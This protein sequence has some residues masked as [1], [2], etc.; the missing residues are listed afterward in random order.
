MEHLREAVAREME[1]LRR[2]HLHLLEEAA[3]WL[4]AP[5][6]WELEEE[7]LHWHVVLRDVFEPDIDVEFVPEAIVVRGV[8]GMRAGVVRQA[9][10][11]VPTPF[12]PRRA[13]IRFRA[14]VL[15]IHVPAE[16]HGR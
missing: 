8:V 10:L 1:R 16:R 14:G 15:E 9:L 7:A 12:D 11:P 6:V 4:E 3:R 5:C 2:R 13:S